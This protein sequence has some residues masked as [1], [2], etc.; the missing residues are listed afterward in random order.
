M[1]S[2]TSRALYVVSQV[3]HSKDMCFAYGIT[4]WLKI[5]SMNNKF[6]EQIK[7]IIVFVNKLNQPLIDCNTPDERT[8]IFARSSNHPTGN[9]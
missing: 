3:Y 9:K 7:R 5:C 4:T 6:E 8:N 2:T 1:V